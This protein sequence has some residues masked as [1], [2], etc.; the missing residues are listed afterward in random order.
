MKAVT[1]A[2]VLAAVLLLGGC[3]T[4]PPKDGTTFD[5]MLGEVSRLSLIHI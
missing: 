1:S 2:R 4:T 3:S 5:A